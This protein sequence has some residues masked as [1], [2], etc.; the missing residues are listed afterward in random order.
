[1]TITLT[2]EQQATAETMATVAGFDSV[3]A[4][5]VRLCKLKKEWERKLAE[6]RKKIAEGDEDYANGRVHVLD[7]AE[8][9]RL[10]AEGKER[11]ATRG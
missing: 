11:L 8:V 1:M 5:I 9:E 10:I 7:E 2:D 6:V 3:Q 4:Y